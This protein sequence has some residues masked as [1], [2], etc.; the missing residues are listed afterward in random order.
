[1]STQH[2]IH[3]AKRI[4]PRLALQIVGLGVGLGL[5]GAGCAS[6]A[7]P[8]TQT[9]PAAR[10]QTAPSAPSRF[11]P[12]AAAAPTCTLASAYFGFDSSTLDEQA[13]N[14][15]G[16]NA[17][18]LKS[19]PGTQVTVVGMTDPSGSEEYNLALGDRRARIAKN[20][21]ATLQVEDE[22]LIPQSVGEEYA[23]GQDESGR[24]RD[25]RADFNLR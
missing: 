21:M 24:A 11:A 12:A 3:P 8:A 10:A 22:R 20:Y 14:S 17:A 9:M 5:V 18:C 19:R 16:E 15:L 6:Q 23:T 2:P 7:A 13:R 4:Q 1:M 25:R